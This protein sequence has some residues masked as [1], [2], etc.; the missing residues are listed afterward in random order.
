MNGHRLLVF[1][2]K[3]AQAMEHV[4]WD[5]LQTKSPPVSELTWWRSIL[6]IL[7]SLVGQKRTWQIVSALVPQQISSPIPG[8]RDTRLRESAMSALSLGVLLA[9]VARL[10]SSQLASSIL[11]LRA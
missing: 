7:R 8:S 1:C 4:R 11:Q 2:L 5:L 9:Q 10:D 3:W 6:H